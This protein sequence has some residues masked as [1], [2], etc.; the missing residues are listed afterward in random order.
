MHNSRLR[1]CVVLRVLGLIKKAAQAQR[2][3]KTRSDER[4]RTVN[5]VGD[6]HCPQADRKRDAPNH[7]YLAWARANSASPV[8]G[9]LSAA[10][11]RGRLRSPIHRAPASQQ[12]LT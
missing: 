8:V 12:M 11:A 5:A 1:I 9:A 2:C 3:G 4:P 7:L 10:R 6:Q